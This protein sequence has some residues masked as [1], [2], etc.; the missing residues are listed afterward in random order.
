MSVIKFEEAAKEAARNEE[1]REIFRTMEQNLKLPETAFQD[2]SMSRIYISKLAWA[3]YSAYSAIIMNAVI[4]LQALKN[5]ID[6]D[7]T[8][9]ERLRGLIKEALPS[10]G[11]K[12][13]EF[14]TGAYYYFLETIEDMILRECEKT[15]KGEEADQE[16]MEKAAAIIKKASELKNS[17]TKEGAEMRS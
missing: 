17:I 2:A 9:K 10:V 1:F 7:F 11:D 4:R 14:D 16:S 5:G 3:Y 8:D 13:D 15:L 12:I 6:K